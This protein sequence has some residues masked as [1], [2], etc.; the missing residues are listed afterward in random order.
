MNASINC[1]LK[2][3]YKVDIFKGGGK[4]RE[5]V[6]STDWFSN[7]ITNVGLNYP[8][9]YPFAQCFM[10]L[11]LGSGNAT[12]NTNA[13]GTGLNIPIQSFKVYDSINGSWVQS[14]QYIGWGAYEIGGPHN[15]SY[16][17][18][19]SSSCGTRFTKQ[20]INFYRAWTIPSGGAEYGTV[21]AEPTGIGIGSFM[22]SP[23]SGT[24]LNGNL[25]FSLV[26]RSIIIPSGYS[27]T[28]TYNLAL[29]FQNYTGYTLFT[30]GPNGN[31]NTGNA[32]TGTNGSELPLLSGWSKLTGIYKQVYPGIM[33]VDSIGACYAPRRG[34]QLEPYLA[35][36]NSLYFYL[37]PDNS[38]FSVGNTGAFSSESGAYNS[39]GLMANYSEWP[40]ANFDVNSNGISSFPA[41]PDNYYY[42]GGSINTVTSDPAYDSLTITNTRLTNLQYISNYSNIP[43]SNPFYNNIGYIS[44]ANQPFAFANY[45]YI[46]F[47]NQYLDYGNRAIVSTSL[48]RTPIPTGGILNT[49][50]GGRSRSVTKKATMSPIKSMGPNSRYGSLTLANMSAGAISLTTADPYVDFIFFDSSGRAGDM[51]HYRL[52]PDIYLAN[53]G[54]GVASAKFYI[55]DS[56]NT[57]P[58]SINRFWGAQAFMGQG[59]DTN[60]NP[61]GIDP[62]NLFINRQVG[63][64]GPSGYLFTG[65]ILNANVTGDDTYNN[66]TG[67]GA[68]YGIVAS[69]GFYQ[70][71]YDICILN[72]APCWDSNL[73]FIGFSGDNGAN[74]VP[75]PTGE[76]G[77][78]C[79]PTSGNKLKLLITGMSYFLSGYGNGTINDSYDRLGTGLTLVNDVTCQGQTVIGSFLNSVTSATLS[80]TDGV[81]PSITMQFL[82]NLSSMI[83]GYSFN[84]TYNRGSGLNLS[85]STLN[86]YSA[87]TTSDFN[88]NPQIWNL[89]GTIFSKPSGSI[90][91]VENIGT[92][93]YR[94]LPNY[95]LPN[96]NNINTYSPA[97]GGAYPG[98]SMQN[99]MDL[100]F[101]FN[102]SGA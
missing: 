40:N 85:L 55:V 46:G 61:S 22:L 94:L 72:T 48:R 54:S 11:S 34:A 41:T 50:I 93:G 80:F 42:G 15:A 81:N 39:N 65:Q 7:D 83:T 89:V 95:A 16:N 45:G 73:N 92:S 43:Y 28:I 36:A 18:P 99:G 20:G 96:N 62:N 1:S 88:S 82:A 67:W 58:S 77:R 71:P 75:N 14:G 13:T 101:T 5:F 51:N 4:T 37:T 17:G 21:L 52:I 53:R 74:S 47:N 100:Y 86:G 87:S 38:Q 10:F 12:T 19:Y 33:F 64:L 9:Y 98:L 49:G 91:H 8:Y 35:N 79:W 32:A 84:P 78:L 66:G 23:S 70:A 24:D 27:A 90:H 69:S 68:V 2:G 31:F 44:A 3:S 57:Q 30:G 63:N 29:N 25:A 6:E 102:W 26:N 76:T 59:V 60:T 56:N 97:R